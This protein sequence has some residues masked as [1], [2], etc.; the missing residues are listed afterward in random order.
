MQLP[1]V[2]AR[3]RSGED[4]LGRVETVGV[5]HAT[6]RLSEPWGIAMPPLPQIAVY[7]L[8]TSGRAVVTVDGVGYPLGPGDF[9]VVPH[10]RGHDITSTPFA[11]ATPL[12]GIEREAVG[13]R[14][15]RLVIEGGGE[16][17][18]LV[19]GAVRFTDLGVG[20]LLAELPPALPVPRSEWTQ[21][22][23]ALIA[24][25]SEQPAAGSDVVTA[26]LADVLL[27]RAV[28]AWWSDSAPDRGWLA[29]L[30]DPFIGRALGVF[31]RAPEQDWSLARMAQLA[32][33]SRSAFAARFTEMARTPAMAYV[34]DWRMDLAA[35]LLAESS[36]TVAAVARRV[37]Y[38]SV[39]GFSRA[40][41]RRHG[42]PPGLWR[43]DPP[44]ELA[45]ALAAVERG[46]A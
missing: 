1:Q 6:S 40:F 34:T 22:L 17:A 35:R 14:Y 45:E 37:G 39:P 21:T 16:R 29:A 9:L 36:L 13:E 11:P 12:A 30:R 41:H 15:E 31:H 27:V 5:F 25:E 2:L 26:R 10:G 46:A 7:H 20:R 3:T 33:L 28:R 23:V 18:A 24:E 19:C 4:L 43:T 38:T 42:R 44:D 8:L 32:G